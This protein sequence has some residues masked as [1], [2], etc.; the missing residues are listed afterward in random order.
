MSLVVRI[1]VLSGVYS[2][3]AGSVGAM[4]VWF[5]S[6]GGA[7]LLLDYAGVVVFAIT[8]ALAAARNRHDFITFAVFAILTGVGGGTLRDLLIAVPVFWIHGSGYLVTCLAGA[9]VVWLMGHRLWRSGALIWLDAVGLAGYAVIGAW[10]SLDVGVPPIVAVVMG[11]ITATFGGILRDLF[12]ESPSVLLQREIYI[13]AAIATACVFVTLRCLAVDVVLCSATAF[14]VGFG[15][16]AG[17]ILWRW[18][19]PEFDRSGG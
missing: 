13:T 12:A 1:F 8:G 3:V 2:F 7:L 17:A 15:L 4:D 16:R 11:T 6:S 18:K 14:I 19:L 9:A 10:K 5:G